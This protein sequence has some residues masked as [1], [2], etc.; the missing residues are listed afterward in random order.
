MF[1]LRKSCS[2]LLVFIAVI[3]GLAALLYVNGVWY[4]FSDPARFQGSELFN[5]YEGVDMSRGF[6]SNFHSHSQSWGGLTNGKGTEEEV[7]EHYKA[8]G[9]DIYE[10]SN[11]HKPDFAGE[12]GLSTYEHGWGMLKAHQLVIGGS[13]VTWLD[14]PVIQNIH[15]KQT[16]L[17]RL[18]RENPKGLVVIAH[19]ALRGA[20][21]ADE[22]CRLSG[23]HAIEAVSKMKLSTRLWDEVST[24]GRYLPLI[25]SDDC[26]NI[27]KADDTG[28]CGTFILSANPGSAAV[29][30]AI[31]EGRSL[32]VE[33]T[34]NTK[35]EP[36][37]K[38][39]AI[40]KPMPVRSI[41]ASGDTVRVET[42]EN[43]KQV[44]VITDASDTLQK[45]ARTDSFTIVLPSH[46]SF[47]RFEFMT[48]DGRRIYTNPLPR[49]TGMRP[50]LAAQPQV[51]FLRTA[52]YR[53]IFLLCV[54]I[55]WVLILRMI[56]VRN[57]KRTPGK[58]KASA[59]YRP[60]I[61]IAA[62]SL[63]PLSRAR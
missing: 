25:G 37:D 3:T 15:Q 33:F 7:R 53:A 36:A 23:V 48:F 34:R 35:G 26:H 18:R 56:Y 2:V 52:G 4:S 42:N 58:P 30:H 17:D 55:F 12:D 41:E 16:I 20:Y 51:D 63:R 47:L 14:F 10:L 19:P 43:I 39:E 5:P 1:L 11:Y 62:P 31:C 50:S 45:I 46:N 24:K 6:M 21:S 28:R 49:T 29:K 13:A 8:L 40:R 57:S 32:A 61:R 38:R 22:L 27:Y 44:L 9:F 60:G 54:A 59:G